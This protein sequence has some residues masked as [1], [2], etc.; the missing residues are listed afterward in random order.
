MRNEKAR[1]YDGRTGL[2]FVEAEQEITRC[3]ESARASVRST[4]SVR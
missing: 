3:F 1:L 2:L 4:L